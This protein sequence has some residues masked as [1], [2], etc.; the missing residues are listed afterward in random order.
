ML[1]GEIIDGGGRPADF[2]GLAGSVASRRRARPLTFV[3]FD[4]LACDGASTMALTYDERRQ[5]LLHL[6][7]LADGALHVVPTYSG[8]D[9]DVLLASCDELAMEGVVAKLRTSTYRPG[10]RS[11][12]WRKLEC[13]GWSG[14]RERRMPGRAARR[15]LPEGHDA[16]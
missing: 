15:R 16:P 10:R 11:D 5:L 14:H 7:S 12:H 3:A 6:A 13:E 8:E 4:L 2:Y 9:L 1:D